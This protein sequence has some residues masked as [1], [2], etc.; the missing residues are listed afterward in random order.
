MTF[1]AT[2]TAKNRVTG[3]DARFDVGGLVPGAN[4]IDL[5]ATADDQ[6]GTQVTASVGVAGAVQVPEPLVFEAPW[7]DAALTFAP[8]GHA[9]SSTV[10]GASAAAASGP[11]RS[12]GAGRTR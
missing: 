10:A 6:S 8:V 11:G 1:A 3:F 5:R 9:P 2:D 4:T 7:P 12:A